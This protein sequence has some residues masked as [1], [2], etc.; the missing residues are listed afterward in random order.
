MGDYVSLDITYSYILDDNY[1]TEAFSYKGT[2]GCFTQGRANDPS[3]S[4]KI[5][6]IQLFNG[7]I[8]EPVQSFIGNPPIRGGV[9]V[10]GEAIYFNS[11][12][13][14]LC[15]G[16]PLFGVKSGLNILG[17]GF[18]TTSGMLSS[19]TGSTQ[20]FSSGATT[21]GGLQKLS[22]NYFA[23]AQLATPL[24]E[25][26][27]PMGQHGR[28]VNVKINYANTTVSANSR[29]LSVLLN[30]R[31]TINTTITSGVTSVTS[32]SVDFYKNSSGN[33]LPTF[34]A[35]KLILAWS[36]G[37]G[38]SDAPGISSVEVFFENVNI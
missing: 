1:V 18:G 4:T 24:V 8:F 21:S 6:K 27:F 36:S 11:D 38:T 20:Y 15:Y 16:S 29:A 17:E 14:V 22:T 33:A 25:P 35:L 13:V 3:V 37:N 32:T 19:F 12:G 2:V 7:N 26:V 30:A 9:E 28:V 31:T 5:N 34:E 23:T 10:L